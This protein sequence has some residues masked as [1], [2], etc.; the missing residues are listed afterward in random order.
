[1]ALPENKLNRR[2]GAGNWTIAEHASHLAQ[3]Q[4]M[5]LERLQLFLGEDRP[6]FV[7]YIPGDA[8]EEEKT[9][10]METKAALAE[11]PQCRQ[12]HLALLEKAD[13]VAWQKN[14]DSSG[15]RPLHPIHP[16]R[17]HSHARPLAH[18]SNGAAL[19]DQG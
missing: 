5:L 18:V 8:E 3:V 11:F 2:R 7:P 19:V 10:E 9:P 13:D 1:M 17:T 4:P 15:I 12:Q 6:K 14:R 16:H